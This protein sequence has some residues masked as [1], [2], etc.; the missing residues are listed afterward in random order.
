VEAI[1]RHVA[2]AIGVRQVEDHL[3]A[4]L[5]EKDLLLR[6]VYHRVK[7]NLQVVTS[8]LSLQASTMHNSEL[9]KAM[10]SSIHR[11]GAMA[12]LHEELNYSAD[13]KK[14]NFQRYVTR[15]VHSLIESYASELQHIQYEVKCDGKELDSS[16]AIPLGLILNEMISN[17]L[18]H[19]FTNGCKSPKITVE[20][21]DPNTLIV[22]DN[23]C[24]I[25][26]FHAELNDNR[27]LGLRIVKLL[28]DQLNAHI[29]LKGPGT[30]YQIT[31]A[32][33]M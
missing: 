21:R 32:P 2:F 8:M 15:L 12:V 27:T 7:N 31:L 4:S 29:E 26:H 19:A 28:A 10:E 25:D 14:V 24:G 20:M 23:G 11:V 22:S 1:A 9:N 3:K 18:K 5:K 30:I 17:S 6:E 13:N 16:T 33:K